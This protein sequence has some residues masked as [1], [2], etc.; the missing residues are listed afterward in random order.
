MQNEKKEFYFWQ[1][2]ISPH[3]IDLLSELAKNNR[4]ILIVQKEIDEYRASQAWSTEVDSNIQLI[5]SPT[6]RDIF[7]LL[8]R[9]KDSFHFFS[10]FFAY[11]LLIRAMLI[12]MLMRRNVYII[13]EA[14]ES[15][16]FKGKLKFYFRTLL[17]MFLKYRIH[18]ILAT[19]KRSE[20]YFR[21]LGYFKNRIYDFG[22]FVNVNPK[23]VAA[24]EKNTKKLLFVGRLVQ[25]K[26]INKLIAAFAL[27]K[28][29]DNE[30]TLDIIGSGELESSLKKQAKDN[31]LY[32][33]GITFLHDMDRSQVLKK[34]EDAGILIL[35]NTGEEGWGVVINEA[36]LLGTPVVCTQYT[37]SNVIVNTKIQGKVIDINE[38]NS[39][40]EAILNL[41]TANKQAILNCARSRLLPKVICEYFHKITSGQQDVFSPW[42]KV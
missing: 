13:S 34:I 5:I 20:T 2:I 27:L 32:G 15:V 17:M 14:V 6:T 16:S 3:Q 41:K 40:F 11:R 42:Y 23:L 7:N 21:G 37:G 22:Y 38:E 26:G 4:V 30:Y 10:G 12:A 8:K 35:P 25:C 24:A 29:T 39:L 33:R 31:G 28:K 36:L 1:N 9:N 19:G 18:G